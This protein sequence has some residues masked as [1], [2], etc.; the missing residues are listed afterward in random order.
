M[1]NKELKATVT[2]TLE[3]AV[4]AISALKEAQKAN[5]E[6]LAKHIDNFDCLDYLCEKRIKRN[7]LIELL[8]NS[9]TYG[10]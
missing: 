3:Q 4:M 6:A 10:K 9:F 5:A 7:N 1:K 2:L 8:E